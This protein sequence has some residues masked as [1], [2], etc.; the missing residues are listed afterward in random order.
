LAITNIHTIHKGAYN[1]IAYICN[2]DKT[3][4]GEYVV[5]N[6]CVSAPSGA[7]R[8]FAETRQ[9][10]GTGRCRNEAQHIIQSF[11]PGEVTPERALLIGQELCKALFNDEYQYVLATHIDH[12]HVHNHIIVN[13]VNFYTGKT[14][15]TEHNQGKIPERA[16]SKL[17]EIS[18]QLCKKHH[19]SVI[20]NPEQSKGKSH[21]EW[22]I[23]KQNLSWKA[24]LKAAIDEVIKVSESFEDFLQ[25]CA[26]FGILADYN[27][28]HKID[29]KFMLA[30]QKERNP[31][32]KFTR[33][34]TLG[35]FYESKQIAR[36]IES[37]KYQMSY[38]PKAKII[39]TTSEKFQQSQGLTNWADRENMKAA[40][41]ALNEMTASN[42][43]LE[44]LEKAAHTALAKFTVMSAPLFRLSDRIHEL[45]EQIPAIE[46]YHEYL[47]YHKKSA[48][49]EGKAKK[50][51]KSDFCYELDQYQEAYKKLIEL[52]P[53]GKVPALKKLRDELESTKTEYAKLN[54]ERKAYKKEADRLSKLAQ[55]KRQSQ[56]TIDR[57]LQNEKAAKRKKGQLE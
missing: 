3:A 48:S 34:K 54:A 4:N 53:D 41:K 18:D 52:F 43:T 28:D 11:P 10:V 26:D 5:S 31:R 56:K 17:R 9:F 8:Q 45:E 7:S 57:Y 47:K 20:E 25:K 38:T 55:Q 24:R 6:L 13:N 30:E 36:R 12:E 2:P 42:S 51:Y 19:L 15:E 37:Y 40:S 23:D 49:L 46:K 44:E 16:W 33:A 22:E 39:R 29:L 27:P 32:A 14:F 35:Y 50:K 1:A 21:Y